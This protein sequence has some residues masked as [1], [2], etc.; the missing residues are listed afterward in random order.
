MS[1]PSDNYYFV[2]GSSLLADVSRLWAQNELLRSR[3]LNL[4]SFFNHFIGE[5]YWKFCNGYR[6]FTIYFV[7]GERRIESHLEIPDFTIPDTVDDFHIKSCG[8]LLGGGVRLQ[9]WMDENAPPQFVLDRLNKAEKAVDTQICCDALQL[10][11]LRKL[12]RLMLYSN[13]FD[14]MPLVE[15]LKHMG[16]NINLFQLSPNRVNAELAKSCDAFHAPNEAELDQMFSPLDSQS[17]APAT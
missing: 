6:R 15:T 5:K 13:D 4:I 9:K 10:A 14:F 17:D 16:C 12:D 7:N 1:S 3:R 8:K 11:G 2:D